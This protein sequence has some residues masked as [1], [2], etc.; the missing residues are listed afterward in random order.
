MPYNT[1]KVTIH[2]HITV[3]STC[4]YLHEVEARYTFN[5]SRAL[6]YFGVANSH[7]LLLSE[8][9]YLLAGARLPQHNPV[10]Q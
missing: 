10:P 5:I 2:V 8:P 4:C 1:Q 9:L 7:T 3:C 6:S